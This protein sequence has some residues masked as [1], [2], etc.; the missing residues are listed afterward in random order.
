M[1]SNFSLGEAL[2][3]TGVDLAGLGEGLA[4]AEQGA[5][6]AVGRIGGFFSNALSGA[7]GFI[8]ANVL[9]AAGGAIV[10]FGK[11]SFA[12]A[13]EA[14][15]GLDR[16]GASIKR[17][18]GDSPV[19]MESALAMADSFK[20]LV[21]G[22][23]DVVLAMTDVGL[24]FSSI[25]KDIFPRFIQQSAD[26]ATV[27]KMEPAKAAEFLGKTLQ[28]MAN[29]GTF[30]AGRLKAAGLTISE[31]A[32]KQIAKMVESG[33]TA[34][35]MTLIM[36]ELAKSTGGAAQV[37]ADSAAGQWAIFKETIA[38]AGEGVMLSLLPALTSLAQ[39]VLPQ[40]TPLVEGLA[41]MLSNLIGWLTGGADLGDAGYAIFELFNRLFGKDVGLQAEQTFYQ[42]VDAIGVVVSWVQ[43]QLPLLLATAQQVWAGLQPVIQALVDIWT[44]NVLPI[45]QMVVAW[46]VA[47]WP[48]IQATIAGVLQFV[49]MLTQQI[50]AGIQAWW[51]AH[52]A[53]VMSIITTLYNALLA[54]IQAG[55]AFV[56]A[57]IAAVLPAITAF[58]ATWGDEISAIVSGV[59]EYL[60]IIFDAFAKLFQG[61][62]R[63]FGEELRKAFDLAWKAIVK[64]VQ[65]AITTVL[66]IDWAAVGFGIIDG[67]RS[68]V[69][70]AAKNLA[71]AALAAGEAALAAIKGFL[72]IN[73]PSTV[74]IEIGAN[75]G[76][77][78]AMGLLSAIPD[79]RAAAQAATGALV[80]TNTQ[81]VSVDARGATVTAGEIE[82]VVRRVLGELGVS[83]DSRQ[84]MGAV[85]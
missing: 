82:S 62:W 19:T 36:D 67:I 54:V 81:N 28:D 14:Q 74:G 30:S 4:K 18:G 73:S 83:A 27:L 33:N 63:G 85:A 24:R 58:W 42:I 34:G 20:N 48:M 39:D 10:N 47:N 51:A 6:G 40:V 52:G 7:L 1:G 43:A 26:L 56:Q 77:S 35:A 9:Q 45:F 84:R 22:S 3:G 49:A 17:L 65:D 13:L 25:G 70:A 32:E 66:N 2:L 69:D 59:F 50:L 72:G 23:D 12:G 78:Q 31:S 80:T 64:V 75:F 60:G 16:L 57:V 53:S 38:D 37:V 5:R 55:L 11:E 76:E 46:V 71:A 44:N 41:G 79:I 61:N 68:G 21:G 15:Q 8:G 29:D